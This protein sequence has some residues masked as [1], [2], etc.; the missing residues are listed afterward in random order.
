VSWGGGLGAGWAVNRR[1]VYN[2]AWKLWRLCAGFERAA[3]SAFPRHVELRGSVS[4]CLHHALQS[5]YP[6]HLSLPHALP[7]SPPPPSPPH[8]PPHP[9]QVPKVYW[10]YSTPEIL[11]LEYCPGT[12]IN[13]GPALDAQ[14]LDRQRLARLAVES[15]LQQILTHGFFH[16]GVLTSCCV[17]VGGGG[18]AGAGGGGGLDVGGADV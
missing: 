17:C 14:G 11:V 4:P 3:W 5:C 6:Y 16:A 10:Q 2:V 1:R 18:S 13:D 7:P 15:Y 12:K 8:P 9:L